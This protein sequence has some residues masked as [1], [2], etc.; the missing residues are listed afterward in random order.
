MKHFIIISSY[1]PN[2]LITFHISQHD[3]PQ[4]RTNRRYIYIQ[5]RFII[6]ISSRG[7][8]SLAVSLSA[9]CKPENQESLWYNSVLILMPENQR[10]RQCT[11]QS[12]RAQ[13]PGAAMSK[14]RRWISQLKKT[15]NLPFLHLF[16]PFRP[17][18][19]WMMPSHIDEG[20]SLL[21]L[22]IQVLSATPSQTH[23][24]I[25]FYQL[26]GLSFSPVRLTHKINL[27]TLTQLC[28]Y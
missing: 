10:D 9:I 27:H 3:S 7:Y 24:E 18:T 11:S 13:D 1:L 8:A 17:S 2:L 22:L 28:S 12:L 5:W 26:S 16:V 15:E 23:P 19:S 4:K 25:M 14:G 6:E 21:S 20:K